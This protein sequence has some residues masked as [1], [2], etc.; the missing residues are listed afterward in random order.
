MWKQ[1]LDSRFRENDTQLDALLFLIV[2]AFGQGLERR[3][4]IPRS[5]AEPGN[6][7]CGARPCIPDADLQK[8]F[9]RRYSFVAIVLS[10]ARIPPV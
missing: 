1:E 6:A 7:Y 8:H 10:R 2:I 4:L 3:P 9:Y 5:Q